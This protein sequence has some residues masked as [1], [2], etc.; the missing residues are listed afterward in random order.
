[1]SVEGFLHQN[2]TITVRM[3]S[4]I[5]H[6]MKNKSDLYT[7]FRSLI[8]YYADGLPRCALRLQSAIGTLHRKQKFQLTQSTLRGLVVLPFKMLTV[9]DDVDMTKKN[10]NVTAK[11]I[12]SV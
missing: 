2:P 10:F 7:F 8:K 9:F 3:S 1:E 5:F 11:E 4:G 6:T 12:A